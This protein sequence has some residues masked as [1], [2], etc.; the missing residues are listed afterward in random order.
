MTTK[1]LVVDDDPDD[2]YLTQRA[3]AATKLDVELGIA[4]NGKEMI[5]LLTKNSKDPLSLPDLI[6][7]DLNMP[8]MDGIRAI[9]AFRKMPT[10]K[11]VFLVAFSTSNAEHDIKR[12]YEHGVD[13]YLA[14]SASFE[15]LTSSFQSLINQWFR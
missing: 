8:E 4:N 5:D 15:E 2:Q 6:L 11:K 13:F 10:S 7:L 12:C 1:I 9:E 14:K 3:F